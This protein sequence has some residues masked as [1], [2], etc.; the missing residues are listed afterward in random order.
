MMKI[1]N[2]VFISSLLILFIVY[3]ITL[4]PGVVQ[5]DSG[6][7]AAVA[8]TLGI[9]HPTGY[10]LFTLIG[11]AFTKIFFFISRIQALNLLSTIY[12]LIGFIFIYKINCLL[13]KNLNQEK[14]VERKKKK[15]VPEMIF[16]DDKKIKI[17]GLVGALSAAFSKTFWLQSTSVEVY[18]LHIAL[19]SVTLFLFLKAYYSSQNQDLNSSLVKL[20]DWLLFAFFLG[21]CFTNHMTSILILPALGYFYFQKFKFTKESFKRILV[22]LIPFFIAL[23]LYVYLSIAASNNPEINWGNPVSWENFK[24]HVMGWQYQSWIFSSTESA[25]KQFKYFLSIYPEEFAYIGLILVLVGI[26]TLFKSN[27]KLL[28]FILL[29]FITCVLYSINYD[30]NDIDS[31]FLLAF[32]SSGFLLTFGIYQLDQKFSKDKI[33]YGFFLIPLTIFI[34][35]FEKVNQKDNT[36]FEEY[37]YSILNSVDKNSIVVS[38]LWD[39][40]ISPSYYIQFVE[41]YRKDISIIDKELVRRSWY[42]NQIKRNYPEIYEKSKHLIDAFLPELQKFERNQKYNPQILEKF[43]KEIIL[44]FILSNI[45][46]RTVYLSPE[47]VTNEIQQGWIALPDSLKLIPDLFLFKVVKDTSYQPIKNLD[48]N[49]HIKNENDYY[50]ETLKNLI[51][52]AHINR[53]FYE[54]RYGQKEIAKKLVNKSLEINPELKL[55]DELLSIE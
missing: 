5:I 25:S 48:Y 4:A 31:Y 26:Y 3:L 52:T 14:T 11:Y 10:P 43:Y 37:T 16:L 15:K 38:Y 33:N 23:S 47:M 49:I 41:N 13:L 32:I 1:R 36:Q 55:P 20:P 44:N 8:S 12:T 40:F 18:S 28:L 24:R 2:F 19:I 54:L 21:L 34:L 7:L 45:N 46:D 50:T 9:A 6:E 30:I 22:M 51:T 27:K 42:F 53:A 39:F 17:I 29:L 35:N